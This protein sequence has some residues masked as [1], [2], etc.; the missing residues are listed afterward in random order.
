MPNDTGQRSGPPC[1]LAEFR[2]PDALLAAAQRLR[3]DG[4]RSF[5]AYSPFPV[6]GLER[7]L[8]VRPPPLGRITAA[9]GIAGLVAGLAVQW[10]T[11]AVDYPLNVG[12]RPLDA[13]TAFALPAVEIGVAGATLTALLALLVLARLPRYHHPLFEAE[14]FGGSRGT[15]FLLAVEPD[16]PRYDPRATRDLLARLDAV[17]IGEVPR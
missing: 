13:W 7:V 2:D 4:Y 10:Y 5:D 11:N 8:A 3:D 6:E 9:G 1:L 14:R 16:D 15:G 12:G 17:W